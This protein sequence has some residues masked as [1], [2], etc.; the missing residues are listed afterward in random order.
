MACFMRRWMASKRKMRSMVSAGGDRHTVLAFQWRRP[1]ALPRMKA[2]LGVVGFGFGACDEARVCCGRPVA[3]VRGDSVRVGDCSSAELGHASSGRASPRR[4]RGR[5]VRGDSGEEPEVVADV[6]ARGAVAADAK[7]RGFQVHHG[8]RP[9]NCWMVQPAARRRKER[10]Y[11]S[12]CMKKSAGE[13]V[14]G[15]VARAVD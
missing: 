9:R 4:F 1:S 2:V 3:P 6:D 7:C 12:A 15:Q 5:G 8:V 10:S 11:S 14:R 13:A